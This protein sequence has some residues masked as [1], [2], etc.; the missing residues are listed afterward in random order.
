MH[1][2]IIHFGKQIFLISFG[3]KTALTDRA[4]AYSVLKV[5]YTLEKYALEKY[6][7]EKCTLKNT[8]WKNTLGT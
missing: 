7:L 6:T 4:F 1:F 2:R 5:T 3:G 8:L